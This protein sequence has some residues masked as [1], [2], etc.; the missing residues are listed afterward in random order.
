M[1]SIEHDRHR[2][3]DQ[4]VI[5][6]CLRGGAKLGV[7]DW[8][9]ERGRGIGSGALFVEVA[10]F[11]GGARFWVQITDSSAEWGGRPPLRPSRP[12]RAVQA[13]SGACAVQ[14][15][16]LPV[17]ARNG[18]SSQNFTAGNWSTCPA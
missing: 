10:V 11:V 4:K 14:S 5:I 17:A 7:E 16:L 6:C 13:N 8:V 1:E 3:T 15:A 12:Q 18:T 2:Q 9:L